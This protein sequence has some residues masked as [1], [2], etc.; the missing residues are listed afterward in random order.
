MALLLTQAQLTEF[1]PVGHSVQWEHGPRQSVRA[2]EDSY[3]RPLLCDELFD[4]VKTEFEMDVLSTA[5]ALLYNTYIVPYLAWK[6]YWH[7]IKFKSY[8]TRDQ[9]VVTPTGQNFGAPD[10]AAIANIEQN[11]LSQAQS[12]EARL[13][14]FLLENA[15]DYPTWGVDCSCSQTKPLDPFIAAV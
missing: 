2:V 1:C 5:N 7:F 8:Q 11:A 14:K 6:S 4:E 9:G 15:A 13:R 10:L 12:Y 3:L